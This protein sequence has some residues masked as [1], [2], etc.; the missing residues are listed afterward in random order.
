MEVETTLPEEEME[1]EMTGEILNDLFSV[2]GN[3]L[4]AKKNL[5]PAK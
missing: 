1:K 5:T 2:L 4:K 3:L